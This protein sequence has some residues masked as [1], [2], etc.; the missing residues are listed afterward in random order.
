MVLIIIL[1]LLTL[2]VA[3]YETNVPNGHHLQRCLRAPAIV[4]HDEEGTYV[5]DTE[6]IGVVHVERVV[7]VG[8]DA[9][10]AGDDAVVLIAHGHMSDGVTKPFL[11]DELRI[12][13]EREAVA[14]MV[15]SVSLDENT[16]VIVG[17]LRGEQY[18]ALN[19]PDVGRVAGV[20]GDGSRRRHLRTKGYCIIVHSTGN[21]LINGVQTVGVA[22]VIDHGAVKL[23]LADMVFLVDGQTIESRIVV[24]RTIITERSHCISQ[25]AV[26][27]NVLHFLGLDDVARNGRLAANEDEQESYNPHYGKY[28]GCFPENG[29]NM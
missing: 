8:I 19:V 13:G 29:D 2:R 11:I 28:A 26:I 10:E 4:E 23:S 21:V 27:E 17:W 16:D 22:G 9:D 5:L 3:T 6:T 1:G 25:M 12:E 15:R 24:G 14:A 7:I 18:V 20:D